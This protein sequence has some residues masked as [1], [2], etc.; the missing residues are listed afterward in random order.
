MLPLGCRNFIIPGNGREDVEDS[1]KHNP[2]ASAVFKAYLCR[3][4]IDAVV[5]YSRKPS[6]DCCWGLGA[7]IG[8]GF[9]EHLAGTPFPAFSLRGVLRLSDLLQAIDLSEQF[10][11][12]NVVHGALVPRVETRDRGT[13]SAMRIG[14]TA[15]RREELVQ[16]VH[17][18]A[19]KLQNQGLYPSTKRIVEQLPKGS[20][21]QWKALTLAIRKVHNEIR[22]STQKSKT[23][24][25]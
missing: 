1:F 4:S 11:C 7:I 8:E 5:L 14:E 22:T 2:A 25:I 24:A 19:A 17:D 10:R 15:R 18:I 6:V 9:D 13:A 20:C 23:P 12:R 21:R 16:A 3:E